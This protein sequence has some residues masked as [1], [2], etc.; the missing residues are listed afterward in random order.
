MSLSAQP[1]QPEDYEGPYVDLDEALDAF[2]AEL[3]SRL[4]NPTEDREI[5]PPAD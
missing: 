2:S 3:E 1:T 5:K 4:Q